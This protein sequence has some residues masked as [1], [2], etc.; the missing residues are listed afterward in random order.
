[1]LSRYIWSHEAVSLHKDLLASCCSSLLLSTT[2]RQPVYF[3]SPWMSNFVLFANPFN[4]WAGLFPDIANQ[5]EIH[6][7]EFLKRLS[8]IRP[9]RLVLVANPTSKAFVRIPA[10]EGTSAIETRFAP[11]TYHEKGI[12]TDE[13]YIEGSMNLTY[14][15]VHRNHEKIVFHPRVGNEDKINLAYI[16]FNRFW[17]KLGEKR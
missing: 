16:H 10:I 7:A 15:G 12:L 17:K 14:S 2:S 3:S 9:V 4:E 8:S 6:F 13:F 11:E 5:V 1:M